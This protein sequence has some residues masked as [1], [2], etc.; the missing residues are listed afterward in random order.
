MRAMAI[1]VFMLA[2][3]AAANLPANAQEAPLA[4]VQAC[5]AIAG[6]ALRLA[7]FDAAVAALKPAAPVEPAKSPSIVPDETP[8]QIALAVT[9]IEEGRDG[10]LRF[11]LA[12]GEVWRQTDSIALKNVGKGPWQAELRKAAL[13]SYMLKVGNKSAVRVTRVS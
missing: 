5:A 12:N 11:T 7:C 13:G 9:A 2:S 6:D 3:G 1:P 10:K 4:S 8:D